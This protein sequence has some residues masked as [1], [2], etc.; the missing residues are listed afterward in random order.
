MK[1]ITV[2]SLFN[3]MGCAAMA[4]QKLGRPFKIYSSEIDKP[5]IIAAQLTHP[6]TVQIGD[7]T[8]VRY[9]AGKLYHEGGV[10]D[11]GRIDMVVGGSPCQGF[12]FAGKNLKFDDPRSKLFFD[13]HRILSEVKKENPSVLFMLENVRMDKP[14]EAVITDYMGVEPLVINSRLVSAQN[15]HRLYWANI[16]GTVA[17]DL[18]GAQKSIIPQPK[19]MGIYIRDIREKDVPKKY[20][21]SDKYIKWITGT[22]RGLSSELTERK[23]IQLND[24]KSSRGL[25]TEPTELVGGRIV[26]RHYENG[27]RVDTPGLETQQYLE[28]REDGKSGCVTTVY[29]DSVILEVEGMPLTERKVIQ[30][31][32][33]K[34][35]GGKQPYQQDRVY[36]VDGI[37]P[38]LCRDKADLIISD[39]E[40]LTDPEPLEKA[41]CFTAGGN[42]GGL[43]SDMT[44]L[45]EAPNG[46][47]YIYKNLRSVDGKGC[48]LLSNS[49]KG[50]RANGMT[51][52]QH[53]HRLRRLT[54]RE[55]MRL[56]TVPEQHID[57]LVSSKISDTQL[58]KMTGNGWTVDV[59]EHI[60]SYIPLALWD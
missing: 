20:Y 55:A 25:L 5:A 59:I 6:D 58:Y 15:R 37:A 53:G 45:N 40:P 26:G 52:F 48:A 12:S 56:Q 28:L 14:S 8:K 27:K 24:D 13:F 30:L 31:N 50:N 21:L 17:V 42:S 10:I 34:S 22:R 2:L 43:H 54:P 51:I 41:N 38:A 16:G 4:L 11:V 36:S 23:V 49:H 57:T 19:D 9:H 3:G 32:D 46:M 1:P 47:A 33:D 7:V 44:V 18:F 35:S 60:F 29:K 39:P